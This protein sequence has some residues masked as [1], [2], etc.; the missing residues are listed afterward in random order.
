MCRLETNTGFR[1]RL[2]HRYKKDFLKKIF[3][4]TFRAHLTSIFF[5]IKYFKNLSNIKQPLI[6]LKI[7]IKRIEE[8]LTNSIYI[9]LYD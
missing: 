7:R 2:F 3:L 1:T 8:F 9:F 6:F 4:N 5:L